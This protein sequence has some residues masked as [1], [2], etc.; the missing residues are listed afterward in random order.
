MAIREIVIRSRRSLRDS[1][2]TRYDPRFMELLWWLITIVL[3]AAGLIGTVLPVFPGTTI[4]LAAAIILRIMLGPEES[5]GWR[6]I[7]VL[8]LLTLA[9]SALVFLS[10]YSGARYFG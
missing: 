8:V 1:R 9:T 5:I 7:R 10:G 2:F 4:I 6:T 3:F